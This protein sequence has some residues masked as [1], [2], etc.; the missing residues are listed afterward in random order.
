M[1]GIACFTG[2]D[3]ELNPLVGVA[4][5]VV[6]LVVMSMF[7]RFATKDDVS[8]FKRETFCL[9][10]RMLEFLCKIAVVNVFLWER[11][12][13]PLLFSLCYSVG[14][15]LLIKATTVRRCTYLGWMFFNMN[16]FMRE[17]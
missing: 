15:S 8:Y 3:A 4:L 14:R 7:P 2:C 11:C 16:I 17:I 9:R 1:L 10:R 12:R 6:F 5:R 13:T